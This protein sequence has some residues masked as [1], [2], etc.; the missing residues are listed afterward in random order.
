MA[1]Q[2]KALASEPE[3]LSSVPE[4]RVVEGKSHL[5]KAVL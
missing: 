1:H 3:D 4:T 5:A 2:V